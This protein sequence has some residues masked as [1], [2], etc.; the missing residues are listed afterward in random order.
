[1]NSENENDKN[2]MFSKI[3]SILESDIDMHVLCRN[4]EKVGEIQIED[5]TDD[6]MI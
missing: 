3:V 6:L 2:L 4:A 5:K 1:M